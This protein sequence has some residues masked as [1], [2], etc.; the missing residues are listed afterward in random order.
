VSSVSGSSARRTC[1]VARFSSS[2]L[3]IAVL[4]ALLAL[5]SGLAFAQED[6]PLQLRPTLEDIQAIQGQSV[7]TLESEQMTDPAA[8]G[9]LPHTDLN[10]DE[11]SQLLQAVFAPAL[12]APA[13]IFDELEVEKFYSNNVALV[14]GSSPEVSGIE[15]GGSATAG[16]PSGLTLLES[17]VPLRTADS[18][19]QPAQVDLGLESVEGGLRPVNPLVEAGIPSELGDGISLGGIGIELAGA[20]EQRSPSIVEDSV[21]FYPNI[22]LDT[23]FVVAPTPT[24]LETLTQ[25]RSAEAPRSQTFE[26][27]LPDG[28]SLASDGEGGA[29]VSHGGTQLLSVPAPT[30][31][32]AEGNAVAVS[33][34][35]SE[36]S[37]TLH[38]SP[39]DSSAYP[40]LVDP[41]YQHYNWFWG[42]NGVV[43]W[44]ISQ[45]ANNIYQATNY[46]ACGQYCPSPLFA[47]APGL[48]IGAGSGYVPGGGQ[49]T[50]NYFVPRFFQ[51]YEAHGSFPTTWIESMVVQGLGFWAGADHSVHPGLVFGVWNPYAS[52][53]A[54][55]NTA[56]IW[57]G[58]NEPDLTNFGTTYSIGT[59][60]DQGAKIGHFAM[61]ASTN[62]LTSYRQTY[63]GAV[64][65]GLADPDV[66]KFG[67]VSSPPWLDGS[68]SPPIGFTVSDAGT[69]IF[70]VYLKNASGQ[71]VGQNN[72]AVPCSGGVSNPC[73]RTWDSSKPMGS[74]NVPAY[75]VANFPQG[76]TNLTLTARDAL[77]NVSS[78]ATVQIK[79]DRT[80]PELS[81]WGN[82]SAKPNF[83]PALTSTRTLGVQ[84]KDGSAAAPQSGVGSLE[85]RLDGNLLKSDTCSTQNCE[86]S[87]ELS[88][89]ISQLSE[90]QHTATI[91]ATDRVGRVSTKE[92]TFGV[93]EDDLAPEILDPLEAS[94]ST[95][96]YEEEAEEDE[97]MMDLVEGPSG[98]VD[99]GIYS[100]TAYVADAYTGIKDTRMLI[101][102]DAF[103]Q[104]LNCSPSWQG[105]DVWHR[106]EID[107]AQLAGGS[108]TIKLTAED[109]RGN[110]ASKAWT[111]RVNP[112][113]EISV[114]EA[115]DVLN[116]AD[117][118]ASS[119]VVSSSNDTLGPEIIEAGL[120]PSLKVTG[121]Q[122]ESVGTP[123]L[124]TMTTD[125]SDGL[126]IHSPE[127]SLHVEPL[128]DGSD[129]P[130]VIESGVAGIAANVLPGIDT[131]VRPEFN[132]VQT[133]QA[134][135]S[136]EASEEFSWEVDLSP[137][138]E[139]KQASDQHAEVVYEDGTTALL[140]SAEQ[141]HDVT[142]TAVKTSL[143][144]DEN[145]LTLRVHHRQGEYA[146]PIVA[147]QAF[148]MS[149]AVITI[150]QPSESEAELS[151]P[152]EPPR[153]KSE[154]PRS[155]PKAWLKAKNGHF[156]A[157][158]KP[159]PRYSP[160]KNA[161]AHWW[162]ERWCHPEGCDVWNVELR[163]LYLKR[164][165]TSLAWTIERVYNP[166]ARCELHLGTG[167]ANLR[168]VPEADIKGA[169]WFGP[170]MVEYKTGQHL[171]SYCH[172]ELVSWPVFDQG[173]WER[174]IAYQVWVYPNGYESDL[175]RDWN[176]PASTG[177]C[178]DL[179]TRPERL[180]YAF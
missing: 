109:W 60:G 47:N 133:F 3:V 117:N 176:P 138:Q 120:N 158:I 74:W 150:S 145:I 162:S 146:Y 152:S 113:G 111:I 136:K 18:T 121:N 163:G 164:Q 95:H 79:V 112:D 68:A 40:I 7:Q 144:I 12:Q 118:T 134:I 59:G 148:E 132:G 91:K 69:G 131:V 139:L 108:H 141:A 90:G 26:L 143:H 103:G 98:W 105:C 35:V 116:A 129:Q 66:P 168:Y 128:V 14:E 54:A 46:A 149:Y 178:I 32:D 130:M 169:N 123:N 33:M 172:F 171:S 6:R 115:F 73:P 106:W 96:G 86:I 34:D 16:S 72:Q 41:L 101:D 97:N 75:N 62:S 142:G 92:I 37:L 110:K 119:N 81:T 31:I 165:T 67:S 177:W 57:H 151:D 39:E 8:A 9:Q 135:R 153:P 25:L 10:R 76:V 173:P 161:V 5:F 124:T 78:P 13:G 43:D 83:D 102:G 71:I 122:V 19:G 11:A 2:R 55:K 180:S 36:K 53:W 93:Y 99:D 63:V 61:N 104:P 44:V 170:Y 22:A 85:L 27:Q 28:A 167:F 20:P 50:W 175:I 137:G 107:T 77:N 155:Y 88:I 160:S 147:G 21:A 154:D 65:I 127:G 1:S 126:T 58:G 156:G 15:A 29:L 125:P 64:T 4:G 179:Y 42:N 51:D 174:C 159:A 48:Y 52:Q 24:G 70:Q 17:T 30:A 84:A 80:A 56:A 23:D 89:D 38:V 49:S 94:S 87:R 82:L 100:F 114:E 140:I 45:N 157:T 166:P